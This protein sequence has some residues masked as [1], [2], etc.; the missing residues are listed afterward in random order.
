MR[1][2]KPD[3]RSVPSRLATWGEPLPELL[4]LA[5][6]VAD[7]YK[8]AYPVRSGVSK[9]GL[10]SV[11]VGQ[12]RINGRARGGGIEL[13]SGRAVVAGRLRAR[14]SEIVEALLARVQ[15]SVR[16]PLA[17]GDSEYAAGLRDTVAAIV[18][19]VLDGVEAEEAWR[20]ALPAVTVEQARRA[21][22]GG[23]ALNTV[24]RRYV[25]GHALLGDIVMEEARELNADAI[26]HLLG[27][28]SALL[29]RLI[30]EVTGAYEDELNRIRRSPA[31]RR[32]ELVQRLLAG[33]PVEL[34]EFDYPFE[35][36]H[37]GLIA[38]GTG[39]R[40]AVLALGA[41]LE[42]RVLAVARGPD[43]VWAWFGATRATT[44]QEVRRRMGAVAPDTVSF[45]L[46]EPAAGIEGWRLTHRQAQAALRVAQQQPAP[47]TA[48]AD[49]ALVALALSDPAL[50]KQLI[51]LYMRGIDGHEPAT[52]GLR[53]ALRAYFQCGRNATAAA[54]RLGV[55]RSTLSSRL[56]TIEAHVGYPLATRL[57]ELE[58]ALRLY[59]L[60]SGS[61]RGT[62]RPPTDQNAGNEPEIPAH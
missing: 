3:R 50:A 21:A 11:E 9:G 8:H 29:Q 47:L 57:A 52:E 45:A 4:T 2:A 49:V 53:Q 44:V 61:D 12:T 6:R 19:Y 56:R 48:Y 25:A 28:Q 14:R 39:A 24:L 35:A 36:S 58:V 59:D 38:T 5:A 41:H 46:G 16:D 30:A 15:E 37:L 54:A 60:R 62:E 31:Q 42:Q 7:G 43:A 18:D 26:R 32:A 27:A 34:A 22:R 17:S 10:Q 1:G 51:A 23:V 40:E 33:E 55:D 20:G 13:A